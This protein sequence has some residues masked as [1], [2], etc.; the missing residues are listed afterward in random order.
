MIGI[1]EIFF[2]LI[3]F[4]KLKLAV[5]EFTSLINNYIPSSLITVINKY[6]S[7]I[8]ND[9]LVWVFISFMTMFLF[10]IIKYFFKRN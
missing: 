1:I 3:H 4:V 8:F 5:P 6:A 9:I 7:D 2:Q 10:Y